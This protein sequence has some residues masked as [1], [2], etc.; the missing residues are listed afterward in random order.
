VTDAELRLSSPEADDRLAERLRGLGPLGVVAMLVVLAGDGLVAPLS[1]VLVLAWARLSRTPWREIG[2]VRPASWLGGAAVG[3]AF[4]GALD[5]LMK[6]VVM[7]LLGAPPINQ[8]YHY[9]DPGGAIL[10]RVAWTPQ[11]SPGAARRKKR[12]ERAR[13][14]TS[15]PVPGALPALGIDQP[16]LAVSCR[17][18]RTRGARPPRNPPP[19]RVPTP[20]VNGLSHV[21]A[22]PH[23]AT[24][25]CYN[26]S[27]PSPE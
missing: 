18:F 8:A 24:P 17:F 3:V 21:G 25:G 7:P 11:R 20:D 6:S 15:A 5:L 23:E 16:F 14:G 4:G 22:G 13:K 19:A 12:Q 1:A 10:L 9:R 27:V 26:T 2:Y